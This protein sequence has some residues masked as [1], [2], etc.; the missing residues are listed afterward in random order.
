[1]SKKIS[2]FVFPLGYETF[3]TG[4][5]IFLGVYCAELLVILQLNLQSTEAGEDF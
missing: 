4:Y 3:I 2:Q 1:M 5:R